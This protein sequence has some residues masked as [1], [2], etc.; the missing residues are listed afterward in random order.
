MRH[1]ATWLA[2]AVV[3]ALVAVASVGPSAVGATASGA[4]TTGAVAPGPTT[5]G[6]PASGAAT[7]GPPVVG[8]VASGAAVGPLAGGGTTQRTAVVGPVTAPAVGPAAANGL[9][10][11]TLKPA[12]TL[13][14]P[15]G[16]VRLLVFLRS[17][18]Q[19]ASG[20]YRAGFVL[21]YNASVLRATN[22][23][24]GRFM[25]RGAETTVRTNR[26]VDD[27]EAGVVRYGVERDPPNGGV[28]GYARFAT[29]T[30]AV[31]PDAP[32]G[33]YDV[34]FERTTVLLTDGGYQR[35]TTYGSTITVTGSAT[36][37]VTAT[38]G[39]RTTGAAVGVV[40]VLVTLVALAGILLGL[41]RV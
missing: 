22:V 11:F 23:T 2:T 27:D 1:G 3:V 29:V 18:P 7:T 12:G 40:A 30:F 14:E 34:A 41:R 26:S 10:E 21:G 4:A 39:D 8:T 13:A 15:G 9:A 36:E 19:V 33:R 35:V 24:R 16:T 28:T 20:A 32:P 5:A 31:R 17:S 37:T 25:Q 6:T 38:A